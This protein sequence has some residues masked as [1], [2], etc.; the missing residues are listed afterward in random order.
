MVTPLL[1]Y[2]GVDA[3]QVMFKLCMKNNFKA[4]M[5]P[6]FDLNPLNL[7]WRIID[8]SWVFMHFFPKYLKLAKMAIVN[9]LGNV[10]DERCFSFFTFLKSKL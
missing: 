5:E 9:V 2:W 4:A 1:D 10:E 6:L 8:A 7:V 3:Q